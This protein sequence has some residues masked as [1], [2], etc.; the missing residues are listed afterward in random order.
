MSEN[1]HNTCVTIKLSI[2]KHSS[3]QRIRANRI[4]LN[5]REALMPYKGIYL[6]K[7]QMIHALSMQMIWVFQSFL[8]HYLVQNRDF[9][10]EKFK[11]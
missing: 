4:T 6:K 10:T 2:L 8:D 7:T 1:L 11:R 5:L 9:K 3:C